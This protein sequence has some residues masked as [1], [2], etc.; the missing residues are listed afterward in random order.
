[1]GAPS[2][3]MTEEQKKALYEKNPGLKEKE[4]AAQKKFNDTPLTTDQ[5]ATYTRNLKNRDALTFENRDKV[6][7]SDW[8]KPVYSG[9]KIDYS[10]FGLSQPDPNDFKAK[11]AYDLTTKAIDQSISQVVSDQKTEALRAVP[12]MLQARNAQRDAQRSSRA[13]A[14]SNRLGGRNQGLSS[15]I[16]YVPSGNTILGG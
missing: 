9:G 10:Y 12:G 5:V 1:M 7:T 3:A 15:P 14:T 8:Y 11:L 13:V 4:A 16:G 2:V 6:L